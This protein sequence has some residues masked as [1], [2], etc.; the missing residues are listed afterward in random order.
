MDV[1]AAFFRKSSWSAYN[2][3]CLEFAELG[4]RLLAVRDSKE[5]GNGPVLIFTDAEW[6]VFTAR[7]KRGEFDFH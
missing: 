2:G 4:S 1:S 3:N 6:T 7:V 5:Q